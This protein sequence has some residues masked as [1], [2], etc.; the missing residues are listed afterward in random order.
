M[1]PVLKYTKNVLEDRALPGTP[2]RRMFSVYM[3]VLLL[4]L[5]W[6]RQQGENGKEKRQKNPWPQLPNPGYYTSELSWCMKYIGLSEAGL[7]ER[8]KREPYPVTG[9]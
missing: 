4:D 7:R 1:F 9:T 3:H 8:Q 5:L 2:L 6:P